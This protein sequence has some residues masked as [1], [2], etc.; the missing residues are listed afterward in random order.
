MPIEWYFYEDFSSFWANCFSSDL[1]LR[2]WDMVVF[3]LSTNELKNRKRALWYLL[4]VP[5]YMIQLNQDSILKSTDPI[6]LKELI[7][8]RTAS[9]NYNPNLFIDEILQII[10][11]VFVKK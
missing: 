1:L 6:Q 10:T 9:L 8:N 7:F 4:A 3:N 2:L 5:I 11:K